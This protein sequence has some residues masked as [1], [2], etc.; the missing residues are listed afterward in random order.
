MVVV[1]HAH[2]QFNNALHAMELGCAA[3]VPRHRLTVKRLVRALAAMLEDPAH[4]LAARRFGEALANEN[5]AERAAIEV[6]A[7]VERHGIR[8]WSEPPSNPRSFR[9]AIGNRYR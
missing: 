2:D 9:R 5:G 6:E 4:A 1:A 8:A 7:M 3:L